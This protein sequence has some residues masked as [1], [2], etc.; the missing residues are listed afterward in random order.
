MLSGALLKQGFPSFPALRLSL[1]TSSLAATQKPVTEVH[2][3]ASLVRLC[4]HIP[5]SPFFLFFFF[6][7][8]IH[9]SA[10]TQIAPGLLLSLCL[11]R[12]LPADARSVDS[13]PCPKKFGIMHV[14]NPSILGGVSYYN[15]PCWYSVS[16]SIIVVSVSFAHP[17]LQPRV[18]SRGLV[19]YPIV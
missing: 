6:F 9:L 11:Q 17:M 16:L 15:A 19:Y 1:T 2:I 4:I 3:L 10:F 12:R 5:L 7:F 13:H 14:A 8:Q 18:S